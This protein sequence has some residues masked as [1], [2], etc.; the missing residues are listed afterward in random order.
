VADSG[1]GVGLRLLEPEEASGEVT[2]VLAG[3]GALLGVVLV[4]DRLQVVDLRRRPRIR[5]RVTRRDRVVLGVHAHQ[6]R[7]ERVEGD[8]GDSGWGDAGA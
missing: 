1:E 2:G 4:E 7:R 3:A 8:A 6:R 5:V